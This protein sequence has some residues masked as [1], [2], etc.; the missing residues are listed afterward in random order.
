MKAA[1][2]IFKSFQHATLPCCAADNLLVFTV[3]TKE[4]EGFKRFR[5]SAQVFN[6]N[7]KH[8][9]SGLKLV[10]KSP[11]IRPGPG[12]RR[13]MAWPRG[14]QNSRWT[15]DPT[16]EIGFGSLCREGRFSDPFHREVI[17]A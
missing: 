8:K 1:F 14:P 4:T 6:Y 17:P 13:R 15:E 12:T 3:A 16:F 10:P 2:H 5:R 9:R 11:S 7:L